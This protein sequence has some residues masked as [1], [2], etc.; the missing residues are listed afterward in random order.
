MPSIGVL[1]KPASGSCNLRCKY[2]FYHS[3]T[4][5][6]RVKSYGFM[7]LETL[8][9][10]VRKA[11]GS[12]D[13]HCVFAFQGGEPTLVGLDFY[14]EL[15]KLQKKHNLKRV[16]IQNAIQTNGMLIDD[17]WARFLAE[18]HFLVGLSLDGPKDIHDNMRTDISGKGSYTKAMEAVRLFN[19]HHTQ[20]NILT[21]VNAN[22]ARHAEK[23]YRFFRKNGFDYLQFIPCLD[24]LGEEPGGHDY[25]LTP[26]KYARFLKAIF[27]LWYEDVIKG[28]PV[29]IRHFDNLVGMLVG[30]APEECGMMGVCGCQFVIEA[31]GSV[32]PCDFYVLDEWRL[33]NIRDMGF[34]ELKLSERAGRFVEVSQNKAR[35]C[36]GCR[37]FYLCRGG[38]RR[39]REPFAEGKPALNYF[40]PAFKELFEYAAPRLHQIAAFLSRK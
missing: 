9:T 23:V 34:E 24:P 5:M 27:D 11:L 2:C 8:E 16:N 13:G 18:N 6:R 17:D 14:R 10:I 40:C 38:C 19:K 33:G 39:S 25:S 30:R 35:E 3:V 32:Y 7:S 37:W 20:Y 21:T 12:A 31:D 29:S 4:E 22:V 15:I 26:E 36:A 1:I 28:E